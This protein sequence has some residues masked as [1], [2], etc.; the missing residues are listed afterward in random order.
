[1]SS[2]MI[3]RRALLLDQLSDARHSVLESEGRISRHKRSLAELQNA[4]RDTAIARELLQMA[5]STH[6]TQIAALD[7]LKLQISQL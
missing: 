4:G 1:M 3:D 6:A 5:E 2:G 7:R